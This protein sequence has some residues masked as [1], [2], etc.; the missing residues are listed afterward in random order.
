MHHEMLE[1]A[2]AGDNVGINIRGVGKKDIQRGDV[3]CDASKPVPV[4]EE[5]LATITIINH[6]TVLAKGYT[7]V[8]HIHTAQV[9]CQITELVAQINPATG[10]VLKENPDFLKNGDVAR[11][12]IVP[13]GNL[14]LET[15]KDNPAM[16][17]FSIRDAGVTVAAGMCTEVTKKKN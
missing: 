3:I 2:D 12:K 15:N 14:C 10:E 7:P 4:V 1:S 5:F 11:V 8:F 6:P 17:R 16:S 9:P 13:K